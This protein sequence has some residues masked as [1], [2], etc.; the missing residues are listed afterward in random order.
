ME[1]GEDAL[2]DDVA[3]LVFG[4]AA[5]KA[6]RGDDVQVVDAL[7]EMEEHRRRVSIDFDH[8]TRS[9]HQALNR[10]RSNATFTAPSRP[11]LIAYAIAS[12]YSPSPNSGP[13]NSSR[14]ISGAASSAS[15]NV[16]RPFR[17][18][19]VPYAYAP[20]TVSS[21]CQI[22]AQSTFSSPGIPTTTTVPPSR[23]NRTAS[24][25]LSARPTHSNVTS[26]PPRS[27]GRFMPSSLRAAVANRTR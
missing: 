15:S 7:A 13:V 3:Y 4:H 12:R 27:S 26:E 2:A 16:F 23:V 18:G 19:S 14:C 10:R 5:V 1:R 25:R 24:L 9:R 11:A 22:G 8:R 20:V 6:E 21:R 17:F